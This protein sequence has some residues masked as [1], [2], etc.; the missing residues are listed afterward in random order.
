MPHF[1]RREV[2]AQPFRH[3]GKRTVRHDGN[4][5]DLLVVVA[6]GVHVRSEAAEPRYAARADHAASWDTEESRG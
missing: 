1:G 3:A 5:F 4:A 2:L 6:D